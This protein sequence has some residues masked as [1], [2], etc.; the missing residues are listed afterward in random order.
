MSPSIHLLLAA[1]L[2]TCLHHSRPS[3]AAPAPPVLTTV[4]RGWTVP[5]TANMPEQMTVDQYDNVYSLDFENDHVAMFDYN[6]TFIRSFTTDNP[7]F[8]GP[9][10]LAVDA[11]LNVYVADSNNYRI[12][13]FDAGGNVVQ[14]YTGGSYNGVAVDA[15]GVLYAF[16]GD[17]FSPVRL[18]QNGSIVQRYNAT[19]WG[20]RGGLA[21]DCNGNL[22]VSDMQNA[23]ALR[24]DAVTGYVLNV[25]TTANPPLNYPWNIAGDCAG[26]VYIADC[27]N[28]RMVQLD[29]NNTVVAIYENSTGYGVAINSKNEVLVAPGGGYNVAMM[30][31]AG[32][33]VAVEQ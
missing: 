29:S 31:R 21:I 10:G 9:T 22:L 18:D 20:N 15:E 6:G 8:K 26:D 13:K 2:L 16:E 19:S 32:Q 28:A 23:R 12:V 14:Q 33:S 17:G 25:W 27:F 4:I 30:A 7:P 11:K 5:Y 3:T 24:I 1:L